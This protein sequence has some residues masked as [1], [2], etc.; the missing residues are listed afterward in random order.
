MVEHLFSVFCYQMAGI[1]S[2]EDNNSMNQMSRQEE[3]VFVFLTD[4]A[5][6]SYRKN[7]GVLCRTAVD[8]NQTSFVGSERH[9]RKVCKSDH[10]FNCDE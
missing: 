4:L 7:G 3:I 8:Y 9:Y 1:I 5:T 2:K 6:S 10:C